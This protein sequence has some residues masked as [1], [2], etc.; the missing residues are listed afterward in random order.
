MGLAGQQ[1]QMLLRPEIEASVS[2]FEVPGG[3]P[4]FTVKVGRRGRAVLTPSGGQ[5]W[6][7]PLPCV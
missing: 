2:M 5:M 6:Q 7:N 4:T 3:W 1:Q